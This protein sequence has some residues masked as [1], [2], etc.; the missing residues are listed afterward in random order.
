M[1]W[2]IFINQILNVAALFPDMNELL[3]TLDNQK[4]T[5]KSS[6]HLLFALAR[7]SKKSESV[8]LGI[9]RTI[10]STEFSRPEYWS[11]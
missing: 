5:P 2:D 10:Q 7:Q 9:P 6:R 8:S 11:G 3:K 1:E 4:E